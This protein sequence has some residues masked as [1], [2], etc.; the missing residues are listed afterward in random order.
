MQQEKS[1]MQKTS[2]VRQTPVNRLCNNNAYM[3]EIL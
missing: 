1:G 3:H 2:C